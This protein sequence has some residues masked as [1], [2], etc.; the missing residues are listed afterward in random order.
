MAGITADARARVVAL[1]ARPSLY[2][3]T[4]AVGRSHT[5]PTPDPD[6]RDSGRRTPRALR[7]S[8]LVSRLLRVMPPGRAQGLHPAPRF[9]QSNGVRS[10]LANNPPLGPAY[11]YTTGSRGLVWR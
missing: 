10:P 8:E 2:A 9:H 7:L 5:T 11:P 6:P 3:L 1:D 4:D